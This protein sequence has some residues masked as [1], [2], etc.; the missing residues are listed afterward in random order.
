MEILSGAS[1]EWKGRLLGCA[2]LG[3]LRG[4]FYLDDVRLVAEE[5]EAII[6]AVCEETDRLPARL[7]LRQNWP[8]PFNSETVIRFSLVEVERVD[9]SVFN[10][11]GQRVAVLAAGKF[12][13][14]EHTLHWD[15]RDARGRPLATGVYIA[16]LQTEQHTVTRKMLLLR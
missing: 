11:S 13:R 12:R 9:I 1:I 14:G 4:T 7:S 6:T 3:N 5:H 2:L 16:R 15:G 8:N 10:V